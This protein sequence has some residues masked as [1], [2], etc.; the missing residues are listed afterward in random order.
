MNEIVKKI[1]GTF[2]WA[3]F[4][5]K[6]Q[7]S[8]AYQ[9]DFGNLSEG[10]VKWLEENGVSVK[11]KGDEKGFYITYKS[12]QYPF[13]P[14]D[15]VG[16]VMDQEIKIGNGSQGV[17]VTGFYEWKFKNKKG[18]SPSAKKVLVTKLIKYEAKE[19]KEEALIDMEDEI[20]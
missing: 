3:N 17:V 8:D 10:A 2:Y 5:E 11:N 6:N 20:L 4:Y 15:D 18:V 13:K 7:L 16:A 1:T 12:K 9:F 19:E 14:L